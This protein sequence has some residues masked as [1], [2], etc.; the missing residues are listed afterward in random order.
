MQLGLLLGM[1]NCSLYHVPSDII[2][3]LFISIMEA[4]DFLFIYHLACHQISPPILF[5]EVYLGRFFYISIG[6]LKYSS[7]LP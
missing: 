7:N 3:P 1:E 4:I 2:I 6:I 5:K